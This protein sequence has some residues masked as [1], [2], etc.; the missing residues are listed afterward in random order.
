MQQSLC[1][2]SPLQP[3]SSPAMSSL[4]VPSPG[5]EFQLSSLPQAALPF[6]QQDMFSRRKSIPRSAGL[7]SS[8]GSLQARQTFP[9]AP[10]SVSG[11][12]YDHLGLYT[13]LHWVYNTNI[14]SIVLTP[15][16][17]SCLPRAFSSR[18]RCRIR[19]CHRITKCTAP[20]RICQ[21]SQPALSCA[22]DPLRLRPSRILPPSS[23]SAAMRVL[24][25]TWPPCTHRPPG[26]EP[27]LPC[28]P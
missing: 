23:T 2:Q 12:Y 9:M 19:T 24:L 21:P 3:A 8:H 18:G 4:D 11:Y 22:A 1:Q 27:G 14:L 10:Q 28:P 25:R 15:T 5:Y 6:D 20:P 7:S 13:C 26:P 17:R 16:N